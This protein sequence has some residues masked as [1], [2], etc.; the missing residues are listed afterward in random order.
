MFLEVL[1]F[2]R[3]VTEVS[4]SVL[5]DYKWKCIKTSWLMIE[6]WFKLLSSFIYSLI[7]TNIMLLYAKQLSAAK[8]VHSLQVE[9][10]SHRLWWKSE[11]WIYIVSIIIYNQIS[12]IKINAMTS[13]FIYWGMLTAN[14][15][16]WSNS[17]KW[18]ERSWCCLESFKFDIISTAMLPEYIS[19]LTICF[20]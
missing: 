6:V 7:T 20:L 10:S 13:V 1:N 12:I 2:C 17:H 5:V 15:H 19:S 14:H 4:Q 11:K 16:Y 3:A 18:S 8:S 9:G